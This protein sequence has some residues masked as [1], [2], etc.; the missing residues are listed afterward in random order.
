MFPNTSSPSSASLSPCDVFATACELK[1][2]LGALERRCTENASTGDELRTHR[3][4]LQREL[5]DLEVVADEERQRTREARLELD[6]LRQAADAHIIPFTFAFPAPSGAATAEQDADEPEGA[7]KPARLFPRNVIPE[8]WKKQLGRTIAPN[9]KAYQRLG[10]PTPRSV[11]GPADRQYGAARMRKMR[12]VL[13]EKV[14]ESG[15]KALPHKAHGANDR[16]VARPLIKKSSL[17][18]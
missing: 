7:D 6:E 11:S 16:L 17:S 3:A 18:A 15:W 10:S 12:R 14:R 1:T 4:E 9:V 2:Q 13:S 5:H 8:S